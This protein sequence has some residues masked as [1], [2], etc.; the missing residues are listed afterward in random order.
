MH[1]RR[2]LGAILVLGLAAACSRSEAPDPAIDVPVRAPLWKDPLSLSLIGNPDTNSESVARLVTDSLVALD[3]DL[4]PVPQLATSWEFGDEGRTLTFRLREDVRWHDGE[5]FTADDVVFTWQKVR[6]PA[7]QAKSFAADLEAVQGVEALDPRTIRVT[8]GA[9]DPNALVSWRVPIL[10]RHAA[11]KEADLLH[12]AF[13]EHPIGCGPFRFVAWE[14]GQEIRLEAFADY[15]EGPPRIPGLTLPILSDDRTAWE[16][17]MGGQIHMLAMTPELARQA[18]RDDRAR[19]FQRK[20]YTPLRVTGIW[21]NTRADEAPFLGEADVR[22]AFSLAL[23]R[24]GFIDSVV[25]REVGIPAATLWHPN[26]PFADPAIR[27]PAHDPVAA[28]E[29]LERAGWT[30]R[31]GD[32]VRERGGKPLAFTLLASTSGQ[33]MAERTAEWVQQELTSVGAR[34]QLKRLEWTACQ[35]RRRSGDFDATVHTVSF[36]PV[37]NLTVLLDSDPALGRMNYGRFSDPETDELLRT[38]RTRTDEPARREA[39]VRLQRRLLE[40]EPVTALYHTRS[41][42]LLPPAL[43]GVE[44]SAVGLF[45]FTPGPRSWHWERGASP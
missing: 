32:G 9:P 41:L 21:W 36:D 42:L 13:A 37:P 40:L 10:P 12:S 5:P 4:D 11:G 1:R 20:T 30:D 39:S 2:A 31:D 28:R 45:G 44:T 34:V 14:R 15:W 16:A 8:Y 26:L 19:A 22:R 29:I 23:N 7:T 18:S 6:D 3:A 38:A 17:L 25:G 35:E 33:A 27:P 43:Q 24:Q